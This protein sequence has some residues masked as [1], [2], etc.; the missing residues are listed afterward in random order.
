MQIIISINMN[1]LKENK[2]GKKGGNGKPE[3]RPQNRESRI[4]G[5]IS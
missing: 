4:G 5:K 2:I 1:L 3:N